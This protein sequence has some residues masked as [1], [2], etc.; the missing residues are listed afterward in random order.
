MMIYDE[1]LGTGLLTDVLPKDAFHELRY[2]DLVTEPEAEVRRLLAYLELPWDDACLAFHES[3]RQVRTASMAQV[4]EPI[5]RGSV[6]RWKR[7]ERFLGPL[8]EALG[9]QADTD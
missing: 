4:R 7:Y 3:K 6:G 9:D 2:E 5:H 1:T 8:I